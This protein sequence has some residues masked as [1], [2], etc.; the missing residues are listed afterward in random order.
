[1]AICS[2]PL[3]TRDLEL[4]SFEGSLPSCWPHS[5]GCTR[6]FLHPYLP[7]ANVHEDV[8]KKIP[9]KFDVVC[10]K[11]AR[12]SPRRLPRE[13]SRQISQCS[14]K[15]TQKW[16]RSVFTC[17]MFCFLPATPGCACVFVCV[18]VVRRTPHLYF[19]PSASNNTVFYDNLT[20]LGLHHWPLGVTLSD[21]S[22]LDQ[23]ENARI[24]VCFLC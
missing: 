12:G 6:I 16:A 11:C 3:Q 13:C 17:P 14:R 23:S 10:V 19:G 2:S 20:K 24:G 1:M 22:S 21:G 4:P 8:H 5:A 18:C 7:V 9:T 15:S